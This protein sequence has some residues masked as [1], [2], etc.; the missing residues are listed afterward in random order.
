MIPPH[1]K[2]LGGKH[3]PRHATLVTAN[4]WSDNLNGSGAGGIAVIPSSHLYLWKPGIQAATGTECI[5]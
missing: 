1:Q 4:S 2:L 3:G 5:G